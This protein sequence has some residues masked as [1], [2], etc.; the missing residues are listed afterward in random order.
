M[1]YRAGI[2]RG[3]WRNNAVTRSVTPSLVGIGTY[4]C[5]VP[6]IPC[7][8]GFSSNSLDGRDDTNESYKRCSDSELKV[9]NS[10]IDPLEGSVMAGVKDENRT[11]CS[12]S[13]MGAEKMFISP[14][15]NPNYLWARKLRRPQSSLV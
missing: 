6:G 14:I 13:G 4:K 11:V 5:P 12:K 3:W 15:P 9:Q 7:P 2:L 10:L 1:R 8:Q